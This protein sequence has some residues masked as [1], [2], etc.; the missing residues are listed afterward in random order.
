MALA[1]SLLHK[2]SMTKKRFKFGL[3]ILGGLTAFLLALLALV[4]APTGAS[5][6]KGPAFGQ[7]QDGGGHSSHANPAYFAPPSEG[8]SN[9]DPHHANGGG[10]SPCTGNACD[11][12]DE[13]APSDGAW[14]YAGGQGGQGGGQGLGQDNGQSPNNDSANQGGQGNPLYA[15]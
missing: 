11:A 15:G 2:S 14:H 9:S 3:A 4:F 6:G 8:G 12:H 1:P 5:A 7:E 13:G 10:G